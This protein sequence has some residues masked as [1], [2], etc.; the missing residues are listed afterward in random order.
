LDDVPED[1]GWK[2]AVESWLVSQLHWNFNFARASTFRVNRDTR[3]GGGF[4][5]GSDFLPAAGAFG[6]LQNFFVPPEL[7]NHVM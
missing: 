5:G 2:L 4:L 7:G 3:E 1:A 6:E